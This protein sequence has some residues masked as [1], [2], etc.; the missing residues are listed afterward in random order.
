MQQ[1][2]R[3]GRSH[4][5][6]ILRSR[7][8]S[9]TASACVLARP[10]PCGR[11]ARRDNYEIFEQATTYV[12]HWPTAPAERTGGEPEFASYRTERCDL[13]G[14]ITS[15]RRREPKCD[16]VRDVRSALTG[17]APLEWFSDSN[18]PGSANR[19]SHDNIHVPPA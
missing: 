14:S 3:A 2:A 12:L 8:A 4:Q 7:K 5:L 18:L 1:F 16:L 17:E 9:T 13:S 15:P 6:R 11:E 19:D 10:L